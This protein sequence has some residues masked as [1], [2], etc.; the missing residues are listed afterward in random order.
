MD[1]NEAT[2]A[3]S[4]SDFTL[5]TE[6]RS[7]RFKVKVTHETYHSFEELVD[8][9]RNSDG[10]YH[11][12]SGNKLHAVV[13]HSI[14]EPEGKAIM[15][16]CLDSQSGEVTR[17]LAKKSQGGNP[18]K[19]GRP[20]AQFYCMHII[21]TEIIESFSGSKRLLLP[22]ITDSWI[23]QFPWPATVMSVLL[24]NAA[25]SSSANAASSS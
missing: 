7:M 21:Q 9:V 5:V 1:I 18:T 24:P 4:A 11:I 6:D 19:G 16:E 2:S 25:S 14:S 12:V 8:A 20:A 13:P 15:V 3:I 22:D 23:H 17:R 10:H